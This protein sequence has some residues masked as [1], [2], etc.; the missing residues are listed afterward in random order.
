MGQDIAGAKSLEQVV[1]RQKV[2]GQEVGHRQTL[3]EVIHTVHSQLVHN[4]QITI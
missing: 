1:M 2:L 3:F 4:L